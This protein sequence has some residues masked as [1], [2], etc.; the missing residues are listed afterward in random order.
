[1]RHAKL[2]DDIGVAWLNHRPGS[3]AAHENPAARRTQ[4]KSTD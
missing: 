3:K 1:M 4:K 2:N